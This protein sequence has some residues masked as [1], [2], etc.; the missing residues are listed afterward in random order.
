MSCS[1]QSAQIMVNHS[2]K[3]PGIVTLFAIKQVFFYF[4]QGSIKIGGSCNQ[5]YQELIIGSLFNQ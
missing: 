5:F 3:Y 4:I 2:M 1:V